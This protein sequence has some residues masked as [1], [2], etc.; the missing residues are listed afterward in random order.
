MVILAALAVGCTSKPEVPPPAS[1]LP[2]AA[3]SPGPPALQ[4]VTLPDLSHV[5]GSVQ[6]QLRQAYGSL[7]QK[8]QSPVETPEQLGHEY[9]ELGKLFM[10]AEY[11]DA[12]EACFLN[13]Q[14]LMP[15]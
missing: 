11:L 5:A 12:A 10:A 2:S 14:R 9:G 15:S 1:S 6:E 8:I 3:K 13:A 4:P 7:S